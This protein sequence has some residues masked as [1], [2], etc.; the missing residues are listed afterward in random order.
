MKFEEFRP[1]QEFVSPS[2]SVTRE[3]IIAFAESYDRQRMHVDDDFARAGTFGDVIASGFMSLAITWQLWLDSGVQG[4]D[5]RGGLALEACRWFKPLRPDTDV[6]AHATI[7][8]T[9]ISSAGHGIV[10]YRLSL[11]DRDDTELVVF[12]TVGIMARSEA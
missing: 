4:D 3:E 7:V 2:R 9:R 5:G 12:T 11:R 1:G 10:T 8:E 6:H